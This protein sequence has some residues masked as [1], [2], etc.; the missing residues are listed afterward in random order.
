ML[1][2]AK[3]LIVDAER[4]DG[5]AIEIGRLFAEGEADKVE[6][7]RRIVS[8]VLKHL[9]CGQR[10]T[11]KQDSL[12]HGQ[13]LPW[14]KANLGILGF[15]PPGPNQAKN[16]ERTAQRL[17]KAWEAN[18]SLASDI[19]GE[20]ALEISRDLW[21]HKYARYGH[22]TGDSEWITPA[23]VAKAVR[24]T[25]GGVIHLDPA[26]NP[27]ANREVI[28]AERF[29]TKEDDALAHDWPAESLYLNPP[30]NHPAVRDFAYTLIDQYM[31]GITRE[32]IWLS[33]AST[34]NEWW[35]D[36]ACRGTRLP[37]RVPQLRQGGGRQSDD[38][39]GTQSVRAVDHLFGRQ[40]R[41][42]LRGVL[43][44]R[45]DFGRGDIRC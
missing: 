18:P 35:R 31:R 17:M 27:V 9:E 39:A 4:A 14:L 29:F 38:P 8:A 32:A 25:F 15:A 36:L 30:Y 33:N 23:N 43:R 10:L 12:R 5:D 21:G 11:E 34:S 44:D 19:G 7:D 26:S 28:K 37:R 20:Q 6:A 13:W 2:V 24:R 42:L 45:V 40:T 16:T 3:G 41:P 1:Q 22:C